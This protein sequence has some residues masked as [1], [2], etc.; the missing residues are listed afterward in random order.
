MKPIGSV[1]YETARLTVVTAARES[2][3]TGVA[4]LAAGTARPGVIMGNVENELAEKLSGTVASTVIRNHDD[5]RQGITE[6]SELFGVAVAHL[7]ET[8]VDLLRASDKDLAS[9]LTEH[10]EQ[11]R[12]DD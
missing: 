8:V 12:S 2:L 5:E 11:P 10:N 6:L 3:L 1:G 4:A 7:A 9:L